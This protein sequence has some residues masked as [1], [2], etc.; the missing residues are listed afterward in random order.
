MSVSVMLMNATSEWSLNIENI[1]SV[2]R[3]TI[4][5]DD[6][7]LSEGMVVFRI[8]NDCVIQTILLSQWCYVILLQSVCSMTQFLYICKFR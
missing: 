8:G 7:K 6:T 5:F 2:V 3:G 4:A 1:E